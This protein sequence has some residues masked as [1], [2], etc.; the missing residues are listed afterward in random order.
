[1][2]IAWH[3]ADHAHQEL[4]ELHDKRS[5]QHRAVEAAIDFR[6]DLGEPPA[7]WAFVLALTAADTDEDDDGWH[8]FRGAVAAVLIYDFCKRAGWNVTVVMDCD[9]SLFDLEGV[10]RVTNTVFTVNGVPRY[11][12][13]TAVDGFDDNGA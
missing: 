4:F 9:D 12:Y 2:G 3:I 8:T 1:M 5:A 11:R 7:C 6:D 13:G 10:Y